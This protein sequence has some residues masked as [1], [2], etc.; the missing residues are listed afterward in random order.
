MKA[1]DISAQLVNAQELH[2]QH[3]ESFEIPCPDELKA[4]AP[5]DFVKICNGKERFWVKITDVDVLGNNLTGIIDN[6]LIDEYIEY[7]YGDMVSFRKCH[8]Y[9]IKEDIR[10]LIK[11]KITEMKISQKT[12]AKLCWTTEA[13]ISNFLNY[14]ADVSLKLLYRICRNLEIQNPA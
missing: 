1:T 4:L 13:I 12:L 5:Y 11:A 2:L 9:T 3:P 6:K 14:K 10:K 7:N 8:V